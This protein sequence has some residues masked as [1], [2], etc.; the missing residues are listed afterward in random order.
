MKHDEM[1]ELF[2]GWNPG[3]D[4]QC[5]SRAYARDPLPFDERVVSE[6]RALWSRELDVYAED[7]IAITDANRIYN[8]R[9]SLMRAAEGLD[10]LSESARLC[11]EN[12]QQLRGYETTTI[13]WLD[14]INEFQMETVS[15]DGY[16]RWS[17]LQ[18]R[19]SSGMAGPEAEVPPAAVPRPP[20][21]GRVAPRGKTA[22]LGRTAQR[23]LVRDDL[24]QE[25]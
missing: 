16:A 1:C 2:G 11:N 9:V 10:R 23:K 15:G 7:P 18:R 6:A 5:A 19:A 22:D 20:R 12:L 13:T 8:V 25:P 14:E 3:S 4:C 24:H 17:E 21:R